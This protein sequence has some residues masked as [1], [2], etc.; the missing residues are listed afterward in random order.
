M[1]TDTDMLGNGR[2]SAERYTGIGRIRFFADLISEGGT[3][4][5]KLTL[6]YHPRR[7]LGSFWRR[8]TLYAQGCGGR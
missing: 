2:Y 4:T 5:A 6:G 8:P 7:G 1:L 3:R